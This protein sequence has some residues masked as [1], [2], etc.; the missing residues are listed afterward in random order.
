MTTPVDSSS[1]AKVEP[2]APPPPPPPPEPKKVVSDRDGGW[3]SGMDAKGLAKDVATLSQTYPEK[4]DEYV[5]AALDKLSG[6]EDGSFAREFVAQSSD[7]S[8]AKLAES[9]D[10][11]KALAQVQSAATTP[12][13]YG[14]GG[15]PQTTTSAEA[16]RVNTIVNNAV[17]GL[18]RNPE[19]GATA[20][21][22]AV[23]GLDA[24]AAKPLV[25]RFV[26]S[27]GNTTITQ[28]ATTPEGRR[29]LTSMAES[30]KAPESKTASGLYDAISSGAILEKQAKPQAQAQ[31]FQRASAAQGEIEKIFVNAPK[32]DDKAKMA[33]YLYGKGDQYAK[34]NAT[35]YLELRGDAPRVLSG[36]SLGNE[37]G[38]A[39]G[40]APNNVPQNAEQQ[41]QFESGNWNYFS[42]KQA[43][44]IKPVTDQIRNIGGENAQVTALPVTVASKEY[45][46]LNLPLFRVETKDG[47]KFVDHIGR[48]YDSFNDWKDNNKLPPGEMTYP[49][50]GHLTAGA[51]G[52]PQLEKGNTPETAD[53][54][55]E[56][57]GRPVLDGVAL[58]GGIVIGGI[59]IF[60]TG[61]LATPLVIAGA[62]IAGYGAVRSGSELYDRASHGQTINPLESG[63]ARSAWLNVGASVV[64][65][66]AAGASLRAVSATTRFATGANEAAQVTRALNT[67]RGFN[68][69]AQ[70]A[71]TAAT[72]DTGYSLAA[73]WD[74]LSGGERML[75]LGQMAFWSAGTVSAAR[76]SGG[77][78]NLYGVQDISAGLSKT[79]AWMKQQLPAG[80]EI[81]RVVGSA[82]DFVADLNPKNYRLVMIAT[83]DGMQLPTIVR[84]TG[85]GDGGASA[86][87]ATS[88]DASTPVTR[89][90][91][92]FPDPAT[93]HANFPHAIEV[94]LN[95]RGQFEGVKNGG[96][97]ARHF[98]SWIAEGGKVYHDA[99]T[100][101]FIYGKTFETSASGSKYVEMAYRAGPP[102]GKSRPD[103]LPYAETAVQITN[104]TGKAESKIKP[105]VGDFAKAWKS[106]ENQLVTERGMTREAAIKYIKDTYDIAPRASGDKKG[107]YPDTSPENFTWHHHQDGRTM[108]LIDQEIHATF[109]HTGGASIA[110]Q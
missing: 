85:S 105:E 41:K 95:T 101:T 94:T 27:T 63:E 82:K 43:E 106:Y 84:M 5:A 29:S 7:A 80:A 109:P 87:R 100:D 17:D 64:G 74:K 23:A 103:F 86:P 54:F 60:S 56:K 14:R 83:P 96:P 8:L 99:A 51:D 44:A 40:I 53:T 32:T 98:E 110:R 20:L 33:E 71:D 58:V 76:Q 52:K 48:K 79:N 36:P 102:D 88:G 13:Y 18:A 108:I 25:D 24:K 90:P 77:F 55:W 72:V 78:K 97:N 49:K 70:F 47:P 35:M 38:Q 73:N 66:A 69:A 89:T 50:D 28:I 21:A 22:Q 6:V 16:Q 92:Q 42:G 3:W 61:G 107:E 2:P 59:A 65:F 26:A 10:G 15:M 39:M 9:P 34:A 19:Q 93:P 1:P 31:S 68:V 45:G 30:L 75:A 46:A 57:Y 104:M 37:V 12:A 81:V 11:L 91:T 4:S 67:A 62:G